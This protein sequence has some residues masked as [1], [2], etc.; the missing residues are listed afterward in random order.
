MHSDAHTDASN[1]LFEFDTALLRWRQISRQAQSQG[2]WPAASDTARLVAAS[3]FLYIMQREWTW[4]DCVDLN[5]LI[6]R[7]P[8]SEG[9]EEM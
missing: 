7:G 9:L 1:D 4:F 5:I 2:A 6:Y 8:I 3:N